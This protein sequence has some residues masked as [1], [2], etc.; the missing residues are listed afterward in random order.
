MIYLADN[1]WDASTPLRDPAAV[2]LGGEA[3]KLSIREI[4][5]R[6]PIIV[7]W[8]GVLPAGR[9]D[10][11]LVSTLDVF[12]TVLDLA[13]ARPVPGTDGRSLLPLLAGQGEF[14]RDH[15]VG[16]GSGLREDGVAHQDR[17]GP[18]QHAWFLRTPEWRYVFAGREG[19]ESL[20]RIEEDPGELHDLAGAHPE[21]LAR[22]RRALLAEIEAMEREPASDPR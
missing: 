22:L 11:R 20:Y 5:Y 1:G 4:G 8:P 13:G 7:S 10:D 18:R 3:G 19:V 12:A 15:V 6:T 21:V 17:A 16:G 14:S 2:W 9:R